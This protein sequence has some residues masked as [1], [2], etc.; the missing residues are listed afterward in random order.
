MLNRL[1]VSALLKSVIGLMAIG[2][3]ATLTVSA[4]DSWNQVQNAG[5]ISVIVDASSNLFKAMHNL[6]NDRS[7]TGRILNTDTTIQPDIEK[8]IL[9]TQDNE[10]SALRSAAT[11]L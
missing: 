5:R 3:V 1:T 8:Y 11:T 7:S 4:W 10:M 9:A 2:V 6:R